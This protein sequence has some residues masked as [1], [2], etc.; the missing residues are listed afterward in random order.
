MSR[1]RTAELDT[2]RWGDSDTLNFI[3]GPGPLV[4]HPTKQLVM[5]ANGEPETFRLFLSVNPTQ[6]PSAGPVSL[7]TRF[8]ITLGVGSTQV[9]YNYVLGYDSALLAITEDQ[10]SLAVPIAFLSNGPAPQVPTNGQAF[11]LTKALPPFSARDIFIKA[12][13]T[14]AGTGTWGEIVTAMAAPQWRD[15]NRPDRQAHWMGPGFAEDPLGYSR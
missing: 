12:F 7:Y 6:S 1:D 10:F 4:E 5:V 3:V 2:I 13:V 8:E 11:V 9:T 15:H 14:A